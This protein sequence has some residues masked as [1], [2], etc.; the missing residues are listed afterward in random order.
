M[1]EMSLEYKFLPICMIDEGTQKA[2]FAKLEGFYVLG[3]LKVKLRH[4]GGR[5]EK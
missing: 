3:L 2:R 1:T 4:S 5:L